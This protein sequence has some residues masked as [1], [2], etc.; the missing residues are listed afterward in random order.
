MQILGCV[1]LIIKVMV[2]KLGAIPEMGILAAENTAG[3]RQKTCRSRPPQKF[4]SDSGSETR[5]SRCLRAERRQA[6]C[7]RSW[8]ASTACRQGKR[9]VRLFARL[10]PLL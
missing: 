4:A 5:G 1:F 8:V 9:G 3:A 7:V 10:R 6:C 2:R